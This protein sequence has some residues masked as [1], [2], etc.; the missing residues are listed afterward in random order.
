MRWEGHV[1]CVGGI[2]II[3]III[4]FI[5]CS[6]VVTRW[7]Y[8]FT[9]RQYTDNTKQIMWKSAGRAPSLRVFEQ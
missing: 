1:A 3:I 2:I 5:N 9:P 4:I 8:T 7:Q 6:W